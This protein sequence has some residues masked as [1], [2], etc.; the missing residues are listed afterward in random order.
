MKWPWSTVALFGLALS[1]LAPPAKA[2][3]N[4]DALRANPLRPGWSGNLETSLAVTRGNVEL[5]DVGGAGRVQW[6]SLYPAQTGLPFVSQRAFLTV[7]GRYADRAGTAF[8]S[9]SFVHARWTAMWHRH[10]G[11]ELFAQDQ[12]NQFQRLQARVVAGGGVRFVLV[13]RPELMVWAGSGLMLEYSR[14]QVADGA[15]DRPETW[16]PRATT[17]LVVRVAALDGR[18]LLQNTFFFQPRI[19][20]L[21]DVRSLGEIELLAKASEVVS[22]G[23]TAAILY[24]SDPPTG[25]KTT[26]GRVLS[27]L[28]LAF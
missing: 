22:F 18:L 28:K 23:T 3:V 20:G 27:V 26:D 25:V 15:A 4:A 10:V 5:F 17:H 2:Q 14:I 8:V 24:D 19:G 13:H 9:Q 12:S 7:S 11:T 16:E 6:Q 21:R 1:G